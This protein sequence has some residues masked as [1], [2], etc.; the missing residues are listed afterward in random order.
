MVWAALWGA[1]GRKPEQ[2]LHQLGGLPV[3][4]G[5]EVR[6]GPQGSATAVAVPDSTGDGP[7]VH[8]GGDQLGDE[9]VTQ[10]MQPALDFKAA[11]QRGKALRYAVGPDRLGAVGLVAEHVGVGRQADPTGKRLFGLLQPA[12]AQQLHHGR[13]NGHAALGAGLGSL[14]VAEL[15]REAGDLATDQHL[16]AVQVDVRPAQPAHLAAPGA[17]H[18][19]QDQEQP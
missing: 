10:V 19:G 16:A 11:G 15:A 2:P 9:E 4:R 1:G 18:H 8:P 17:Q 6:I 12:G 3:L 5:L 7:H 13:P 14:L